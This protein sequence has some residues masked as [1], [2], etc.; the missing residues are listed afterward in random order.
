MTDPEVNP[1]TTLDSR[2]VYRNSWISVR[3]DKVIRPDGNEGIYGVVDTR[4]ATGVVPLTEN[5]DTYLVGQ[6]RYTM[7]CYSWEIPEGGTD[8]DEDP[9]SACQRELREET[10]LVARHWEQLGGEI[11]ISNCISSERCF[12]YAAT[13]L[14]MFEAA[15]DG[16][17]ILQLRKLPLADAFAM[18]EDGSIQDSISIIGLHRAARRYDIA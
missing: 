1:W 17:E 4:I 11:H 15:P 2:E 10:G 12:V 13:G 5:L 9:L 18:V 8:E 16:T 14:E 7:D 3:E 6:Y